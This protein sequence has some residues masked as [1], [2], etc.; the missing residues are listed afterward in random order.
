V[1]TTVG[2]STSFGIGC[3]YALGKDSCVR[4]KVDNSSVVSADLFLQCWT[5]GSADFWD[6]G[7]GV[8]RIRILPFYDKCVERTEIM[9]ANKNLIQTYAKFF[10]TVDYV[11]V[12][13]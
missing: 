4:A 8:A 11:P 13:K 9:L 3:K 7:F 5:S 6:S 1:N 10:K 2:G 12:S